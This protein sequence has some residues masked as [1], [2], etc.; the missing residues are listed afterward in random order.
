M[1]IEEPNYVDIMNYLKAILFWSSDWTLVQLIEVKIGTSF[2][3]CIYPNEIRRMHLLKIGICFIFER[4]PSKFWRAHQGW[5]ALLFH[6]AHWNMR[7]F[8]CIKFHSQTHLIIINN[9]CSCIA[10][11]TYPKQMLLLPLGADFFP[12]SLTPPFVLLQ[13]QMRKN[14]QVY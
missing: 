1:Q 5:L 13:E 11:Q 7:I 10:N 9:F 14:L 6:F 2:D 8:S 4:H 12:T 3:S